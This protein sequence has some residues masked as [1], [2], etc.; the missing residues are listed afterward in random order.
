[1]IPRESAHGSV[2]CAPVSSALGGCGSR[3]VQTLP[4]LLLKDTELL[5]KTTPGI[6]CGHHWGRKTQSGLQLGSL[7]DACSLDKSSWHTAGQRQGSWETSEVPGSG[8]VLL[9]FSL[10][11]VRS[12]KAAH[13]LP[14]A[15]H[16]PMMGDQ[17]LQSNKDNHPHPPI[18][19]PFSGSQGLEKQG[20]ENSIS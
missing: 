6:F 8:C 17:Y 13:H 10:P 11:M 5:Q 1:M 12:R 16:R 3:I 20:P 19:C 14:G 15:W 4:F 2:P 18:I 9:V 7:R